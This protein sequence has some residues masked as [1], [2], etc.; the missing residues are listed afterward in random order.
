[1]SE[2]YKPMN[3][4]CDFNDDNKLN[5]TKRYLIN[6]S[7][8]YHQDN[9]ESERARKYQYWL[10]NKEKMKELARRNY[11][12]HRSWGGN[13]KDGKEGSLLRVSI[14]VFQ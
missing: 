4:V 13:G 11:A 6:Q 1:M 5:K 9:L 8:Q 10:D 3:D 7:R 12:A 14:A 2:A